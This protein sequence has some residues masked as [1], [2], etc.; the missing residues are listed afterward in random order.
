MENRR[1]LV[2]ANN[3]NCNHDK[4][5]AELGFISWNPQNRK[6]CVGD[7]VYIYMSK[8]CAVRYKTKVTAIKIQRED[9][10]YWYVTPTEG[11]SCKLEL[12]AEYNGTL[13]TSVEM[14]K[15]GFKGGRSIELP[16]CNNDQLL[17]YIEEQ[18][19]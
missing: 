1:W 17:D 10:E 5:F 15:H 6:F 11:L 4:A 19:K 14:K 8:D 18:F 12:V 7:I 9:W 3:E 2:Y 16:M 13:L